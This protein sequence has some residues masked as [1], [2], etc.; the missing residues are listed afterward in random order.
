MFT[1][2][3]LQ[4][5]EIVSRA[6]FLTGDKAARAARLLSSKT[7]RRYQVRKAPER[8]ALDW[9]ERERGRFERGEYIP[10]L[11][12]L[13]GFAPKDH[14]AHVAKKAPSKIAYTQNEL[15]GRADK[16]SLLSIRSYIDLIS[17]NHIDEDT[18]VYLERRQRDW[19]QDQSK[20]LL[21]AGP[22]TDKATADLMESV[23]T[24]YSQEGHGV[25]NSCMRYTANNF[26]CYVDGRRTHPVRAYAGGDLAIAYTVNEE[27]KT[28]ARA[29]VWPEKKIYSRV[30]GD[31]DT[32]HRLLKDRGY[33][34]SSYYDSNANSLL[35]AK[36]A[37]I[38][39][40]NGGVLCPYLDEVQTVSDCGDYLEIGGELQASQVNGIV[41][42]VE[43]QECEH[44]G[45]RYDEEDM[46]CVY[47]DARMNDSVSWCENCQ[48]HAAFY[49]EGYEEWFADSADH[50]E[51]GGSTYCLRYLQN[52]E[53]ANY[54]DHYECWMFSETYP[55][56][57]NESGY[58][59]NWCED[60]IIGNAT[61][62]DGEYY[63]ND[64]SDIETLHIK[65]S[66][67]RDL[68]P[69]RIQREREIVSKTLPLNYVQF[70]GITGLD[71][72]QALSAWNQCHGMGA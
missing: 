35:G 32:L 43:Q 13:A 19:A 39:L 49:C 67:Q 26:S 37:R 38:E 42:I 47:L 54:C 63:S 52:N 45:D 51:V 55:V 41:H 33:T 53:D 70:F 21:F 61:G 24:N 56:V 62:V 11:S 2:I 64:L 16:Q 50:E 10:L 72:D 44:C 40:D 69:I 66:N 31:D 48:D 58:Q 60:A 71:K 7:C 17:P 12:V 5:G 18:R 8:S 9:R 27:G 34:K 14:F 25:S 57:V 68:A 6:Q 3:A 23:Y 29:L 15:K 1:L 36:L 28:T 30:Y 59:E 20:E 65:L 46:R 4:S 22:G